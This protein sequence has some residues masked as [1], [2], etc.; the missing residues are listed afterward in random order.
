MKIPI[1]IIL[2]VDKN[3]HQI[4]PK[5]FTSLKPD[6]GAYGYLHTFALR[7]TSSLESPTLLLPHLKDW[8]WS[9]L[10]L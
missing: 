6:L 2:F 9:C 5:L 4:L 3:H 8:A 7:W 10:L 1:K